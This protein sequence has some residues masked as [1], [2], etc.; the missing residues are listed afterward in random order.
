M[1]REPARQSLW[2]QPRASLSLEHS[3]AKRSENLMDI[4]GEDLGRPLQEGVFEGL[5]RRENLDLLCIQARNAF[6]KYDIK[7]AFKLS[8]E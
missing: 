1:N 7:T 6:L 4:E 5:V 3:K 2:P 8:R